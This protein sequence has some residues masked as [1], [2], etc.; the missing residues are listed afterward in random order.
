MQSTD[1]RISI[2][3]RPTRSASPRTSLSAPHGVGFDSNGNL[4]VA[5]T[6]NNRVL[7]FSAATLDLPNPEADLVVGQADFTTGGTDRSGAGSSGAGFNSPYGLAFDRQ[8]NLYV[9]DV[10]NTRV[11]KFS[12]PYATAIQVFG[13]PDFKS[14]GVPR[15]P[16]SQSL[17][18]PTGVAVDASGNVYVAVQTDNR[19]LVFAGDGV[20]GAAA[21]AVLG[22]AGFNS[23]QPNAGVFPR[24]SAGS[25]YSPSDVKADAAGNIYVADTGN[26][27]SCC[28]RP[29]ARPRDKYGAR[30]TFHQTE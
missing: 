6:G 3:G 9:A 1:R 24:A 14:R 13:Q 29:T 26:N 20:N 7:R 17:A 30:S 16:T 11:L 28:S 12:Q 18:G 21:K 15:D 8:N 5:D 23:T 4:W 22:Q 10:L 25:L 27:R 2:H 19:V